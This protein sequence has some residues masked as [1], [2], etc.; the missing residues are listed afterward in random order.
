MTAKEI[1]KEL[2]ADGW[3]EIGQRGSYLNLK[4]PTKPDSFRRPPERN[5]KQYSQTGG[6]EI[7]LPPKKVKEQCICVK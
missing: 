7:A 5:T 6:A 4:H 1:L 3:Y 2:H